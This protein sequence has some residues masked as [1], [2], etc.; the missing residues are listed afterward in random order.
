[1]VEDE[2]LEP[3]CRRCGATPSSDPKKTITF[4]EVD[5]WED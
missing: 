4:R 3:A 1:M 2:P 5:T